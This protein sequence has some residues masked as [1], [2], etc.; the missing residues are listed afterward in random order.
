M[1]E[2]VAG[3]HYSDDWDSPNEFKPERFLKNENSSEQ[4][5]SCE[6][7]SRSVKTEHVE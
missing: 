3:V 1:R 5:K 7:N 2:N 4:M 6:L